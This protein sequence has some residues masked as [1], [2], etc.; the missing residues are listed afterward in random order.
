MIF[1]LLGHGSTKEVVGL[2]AGYMA[3]RMLY[4]VA[5]I[6]AETERSSY[7]RGAFWWVGNAACFWAMIRG[8]R[9]FGGDE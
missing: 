4:A 8:A 3:A 2:G 7:L 1:L 6:T 5:Y 9:G